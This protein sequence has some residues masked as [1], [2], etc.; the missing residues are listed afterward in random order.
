[1]LGYLI[2]KKNLQSQVFDTEGKRIPVTTISTG[3]CYVVDIKQNELTNRVSVVLGLQHT[4]NAN[5]PKQGMFKKAGIETPLHFL[6]EF[7]MNSEIVLETDESGKK[8][9][10]VGEKK[11][12]IGDVVKASDI[13]Q[14]G[15]IVSV[16]GI[17]KGKGFQGVVKRHNFRG[18]PRTHGQSDRERA[19]GSLGQTTTP[20]RVYKGKRMAGRMGNDR[21]TVK[22][23]PVI[24]IGESEMTVKGLVPGSR[25]GLLEVKIER[26]A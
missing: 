15:D 20:G 18:G 3:E 10:S 6:R 12:A 21:I 25:N 13:F 2:G 23:L 22:N 8:T 9:L 16:S 1:M 14:A 5:K 26:N 4:K 17:S 19:P 11:F 7:T 24:A